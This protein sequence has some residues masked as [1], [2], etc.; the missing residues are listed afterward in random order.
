MIKRKRQNNRA[1]GTKY[2]EMAAKYLEKK[3][4][5]VVQKNYR[6]PYAEI[7]LLLEKDHTWIFCEVKFR[8]NNNCGNPLDAVTKQKQRRISRAA[9]QF[10]ASHGYEEYACRFDVI[11]INGDGTIQHIENAFEFCG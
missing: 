5:R 9:L 3:G 1:T 10:Y 11:A 2:E 7:D 6:T 4:Y 8:S